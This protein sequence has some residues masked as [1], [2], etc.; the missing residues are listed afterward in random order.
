MRVNLE[1][2]CGDTFTNT[3]EDAKE[4]AFKRN[5][6]VQ[7]DFNG[8][9]CVVNSLT[10]LVNL[11]KDYKNA[12]TMDWKEIGP[13]CGDEYDTETQKELDDKIEQREESSRLSRAKWAEEQVK[14]LAEL[15]KEIGESIIELKDE[16]NWNKIVEVNADPYG[17]AS[18]DYARNWA[19][20][21]QSE[22]AKGN[23]LI[24]CAEKTSHDADVDGITGFMYGMAVSILSQC[25][26]H[27]E[28]LRKWHN[29]D[30]GHDG[31]GVVNPAVLTIGK[32]ED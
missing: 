18:V 11:E 30:Y 14:K 5:V 4:V 16:A 31:D 28:E 23:T 8:V 9:M 17:K 7:F 3:A 24:E 32:K 12:H 26:K 2:M 19:I 22:M 1:T 13:V 21:M 25:W 20:L 6:T 27:G 29:K 15:S 10:N